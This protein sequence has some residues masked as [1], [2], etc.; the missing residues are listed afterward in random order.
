MSSDDDRD[1]DDGQRQQ[2]SRR[3]SADRADTQRER[4]EAEQPRG[5]AELSR[6][7]GRT[8]TQQRERDETAAAAARRSGPTARPA[9]LLERRDVGGATLHRRRARVRAALGV[10]LR[11]TP[12]APPEPVTCADFFSPP[13]RAQLPR[14]KPPFFGCSFFFGFLS[15]AFFAVAGQARR[16]TR[17]DG[18]D[19]GHRHRLVGDVRRVARVDAWPWTRASATR[20]AWS[21]CRARS[22][23]SGCEANRPCFSRRRSC[24]ARSAS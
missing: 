2:P 10:L 5:A 1:D 4:V 12:R 11:S 23:I 24:C 3:A 6:R 13:L 16:R 20:S 19:L 9:F 8:A 21:A 17:F 22:F 14:P 15:S 7:A 18:G